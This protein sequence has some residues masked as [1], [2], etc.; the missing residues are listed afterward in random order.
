MPK[1]VLSNS[2]DIQRDGRDRVCECEKASLKFDQ[3]SADD[4]TFLS[5]LGIV[6]D[7]FSAKIR[8]SYFKNK[9]YLRL[10]HVLKIGEICKSERVLV[11][12]VFL[13]DGSF[14]FHF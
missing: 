7:S 12:V 13:S 2:V 1:K 5:V 3:F 9:L 11:Q 4:K 10:D 6:C 14:I 8:E